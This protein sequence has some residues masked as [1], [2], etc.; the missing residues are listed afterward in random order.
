MFLLVWGNVKGIGYCT[1][2]AE[3]LVG[4][5]PDEGCAGLVR[6]RCSEKPGPIKINKHTR[7]SQIEGLAVPLRVRFF[8]HLSFYAGAVP[9]RA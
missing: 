2:R 8:G 3:L 7:T 4:A 1:F 9:M 5:L 6:S